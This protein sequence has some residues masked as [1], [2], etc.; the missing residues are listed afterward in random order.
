MYNTI[1]KYLNICY[2]YL[3]ATS[4]ESLSYKQKL[5]GGEIMAVNEA[6][7]RVAQ[8]VAQ[9]LR[10]D[11]LPQSA[12]EARHRRGEWLTGDDLWLA[13]GEFS[14]HGSTKKAPGQT[15]ENPMKA[16]D[17]TA[18]IVQGQIESFLQG[19]LLEQSKALAV[20]EGVDYT[21][22]HVDKVYARWI[23]QGLANNAIREVA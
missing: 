21:V 14:A 22:A 2:I 1:D 15:S 20:L 11:I 12:E 8:L 13:L 9:L 3:N 23:E 10:E 4:D 19:E 16:K 5:I 18:D 6:K 17:C 7:R